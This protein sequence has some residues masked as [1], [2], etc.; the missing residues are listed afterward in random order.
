MKHKQNCQYIGVTYWPSTEPS[1]KRF[2]GVNKQKTSET[3]ASGRRYRNITLTCE[4][5]WIQYVYA[6]R[7]QVGVRQLYNQV[8]QTA[9]GSQSVRVAVPV[10]DKV[11]AWEPAPD[12][13]L[14]PSVTHS[15]AAQPEC[16]RCAAMVRRTLGQY[17][18]VCPRL[19]LTPHTQE[20]STLSNK[21][22]EVYFYKVC[23]FVHW[24]LSLLLTMSPRIYVYVYVHMYYEYT[25]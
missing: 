19:Q 23:S 9:W 12:R 14:G 4:R 3:D 2:T 21:V 15:W 17:V 6:H 7:K 24:R 11:P 13:G 16:E 20:T 1:I 18:A 8:P 5:G 22:R 10:G 25:T